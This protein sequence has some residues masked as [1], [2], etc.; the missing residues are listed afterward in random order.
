MVVEHIAEE[1]GFISAVLE[2]VMNAPCQSGDCSVWTRGFLV[3][4]L[5]HSAIFLVGDFEGGSVRR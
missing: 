5:A 4:C 3:D 2:D 1:I